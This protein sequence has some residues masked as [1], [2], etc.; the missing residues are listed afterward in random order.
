MRQ[1]MCSSNFNEYSPGA[2]ENAAKAGTAILQEGPSLYINGFMTPQLG[3]LV[4][5]RY[6]RHQFTL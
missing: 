3:I 2:I 1:L 6:I 5:Q 4:T